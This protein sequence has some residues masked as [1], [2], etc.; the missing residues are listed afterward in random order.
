MAAVLNGKEIAGNVRAKLKEEVS[1]LN[2]KYPDKT[3]CLTIV[4]VGDRD[5]SNVYIRMKRKAGEEVGVDVRHLKLAKE[6]T[7]E[8]IVKR[9]VSL[10]ADPSVHGII[11]QLPLDTVSK[12]DE[13]KCTNAISYSKDVDGL[14]DCSLG[15]L[16]GGALD[17]CN[18]PCTPLGCLELIEQSGVDIRGKRAVV[19]GR[20]KIVV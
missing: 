12:V 2:L 13:M 15:R 4:Q 6:S 20:S 3:P 17:G 10:N 9:I 19:I 18:I 7:E 5:D 14:T 1:K 11:L 16:S 8:D